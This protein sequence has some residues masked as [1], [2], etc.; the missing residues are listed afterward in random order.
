MAVSRNSEHAGRRAFVVGA[1]GLVGQQL[2]ALLLADPAYASVDVLARRPLQQNHAKLA[3]HVVDFARLAD[4]AWPAVDDLFCCL[5]TTIRN[6]GSREA[7]RSVDYDYPLAL[8]T[9]A[10][11]RGA[12]QF[13]FVSAMGADAHSRVFYS[14][15]KGELEAGVAALAYPAAI[16]LRPSLLAG[17]RAEHRPGERIALK[18]LQPLRHLVPRQYRPVADV[19]VARAMIAYAQRRLTGFHVVESG[20]IQAFGAPR[21]K[22]P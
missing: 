7:F 14:R 10:L 22:T 4:F 17:K 8:A 2:L 1:T 13:L 16:A 11:T 5:G 15:V 12:R 18:V 6:A 19:A 21:R 9:G 20:D 3:A